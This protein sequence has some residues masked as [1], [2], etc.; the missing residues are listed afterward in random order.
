FIPFRSGASTSQHALVMAV[1]RQ[2]IQTSGIHSLYRDADLLRVPQQL[3]RPRVTAPLFH[4]EFQNALWP[5]FQYSRHCMPT[6]DQ[7]W[8]SAHAAL[9]AIRAYDTEF[10]SIR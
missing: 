4:P 7:N 3:L 8:L 2:S 5:G 1:L 6:F 9:R 10:K